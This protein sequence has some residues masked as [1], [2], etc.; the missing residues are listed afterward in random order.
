MKIKK[1]VVPLFAI[2]LFGAI[3]C[4]E[5]PGSELVSGVNDGNGGDAILCKTDQGPKVMMLD[6]WEGTKVLRRLGYTFDLGPGETYR[7]KV[8]YV[9]K[10]LETFDKLRAQKYRKWFAAFE[11]DPNERE[12]GPL[13]LVIQGDTGHQA[14]PTEMDG[15]TCNEVSL[16]R[17]A[18]QRRDPILRG[19]VRYLISETIWN[20]LNPTGKAMLALHELI[21]REAADHPTAE[22]VRYFNMHIM[23]T[24]MDN[25][26]NLSKYA[27]L[28][29]KEAAIRTLVQNEVEF[30]K[31]DLAY[32]G[33]PV[34]IYD[35][36]FQL[37]LN[38]DKNIR[39]YPSGMLK[40]AK[41]GNGYKLIDVNWEEIE[42]K[43]KRN[44]KCNHFFFN[45]LGLVTK[46]T[47]DVDCYGN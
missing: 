15:S 10:R 7:A 4:G 45:E 25:K 6:E 38:A 1:F 14:L 20:L 36:K 16:V 12:I 22:R 23:S 42:I 30:D 18:F 46:I 35:R 24:F 27:Y 29:Y 2:G 41:S 8:L 34:T 32:S 47:D 43:Q 5:Q 19:K 31:R 21:Y 33:N 26:E 9:L 44:G 13:E 37:D 11:E 40:S 39:F 3:S 28:L 17:A